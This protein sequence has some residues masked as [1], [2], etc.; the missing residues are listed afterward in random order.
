MIFFVRY[1]LLVSSLFR[2]FVHSER[3]TGRRQKSAQKFE[4]NVTSIVAFVSGM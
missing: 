1:I 4:K 3:K 2:I